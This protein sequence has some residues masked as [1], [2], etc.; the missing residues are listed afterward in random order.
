MTF[1]SRGWDIN[2]SPNRQPRG[3]MRCNSSGLS[4][5]TCP[6]LLNFQGPRSQM[7]TKAHKPAITFMSNTWGR[8]LIKGWNYQEKLGAP[9]PDISLRRTSTKLLCRSVQR[10]C[11]LEKYNYTTYYYQCE[12]KCFLTSSRIE[13]A[14]VRIMKAR[15]KR[16]HNLL[17]A[18]VSIHPGDKLPKDQFF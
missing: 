1:F 18:E 3:V 2:P 9:K 8:C 16:P 13:A 14:I 17:V 5:K 4:P 15:K 12:W 10:K 6:A 7:V 11:G